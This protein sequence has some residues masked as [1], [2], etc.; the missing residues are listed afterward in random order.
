MRACIDCNRMI[1][2]WIQAD[3][4]SIGYSAPQH[5]CMHCLS[6]YIPLR[7]T[8]QRTASTMSMSILFYYL[9]FYLPMIPGWRIRSSWW[10]SR[11]S[12]AAIPSSRCTIKPLTLMASHSGFLTAQSCS[13]FSL[14]SLSHVTAC[15]FHSR[16][17]I[18]ASGRSCLVELDRDAFCRQAQFGPNDGPPTR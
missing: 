7:I 5:A 4:G 16:A 8:E 15:S 14:F 11:S 12:F 9:T 10:V 6:G 3:S 17:E 13:L 2:H 1:S 18:S